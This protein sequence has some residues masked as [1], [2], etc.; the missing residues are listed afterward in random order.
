MIG[1]KYLQNLVLFQ[2]TSILND[3]LPPI[4]QI[5]HIGQQSTTYAIWSEGSCD[6][7]SIKLDQPINT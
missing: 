4:I 1:G 5:N 2:K 3:T 7:K 6:T